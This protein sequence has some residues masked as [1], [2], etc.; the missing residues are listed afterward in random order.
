MGTLKEL[1]SG[2]EGKESPAVQERVQFLGRE[3]PLE[4]GMATHSR[5]VF[6]PGEFLAGCKSMG[7][8]R[9]GHNSVTNTFTFIH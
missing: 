6:L 9:V 7:S 1:P 4:K 8:R 5:Q 3:D 2:S